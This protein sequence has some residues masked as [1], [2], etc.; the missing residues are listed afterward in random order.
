ARRS[1]YGTTVA[2]GRP[3]RS[4]AAWSR[5]T[6]RH[7]RLPTTTRSNRPA[8]DLLRDGDVA[9]GLASIFVGLPPIVGVQVDPQ[10]GQAIDQRRGDVM[11]VDVEP[12]QPG[13]VGAL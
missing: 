12:L 10:G 7:P 1:R 6:R 5:A 4:R 13:D 2:A 11:M 9:I 3:R 8:P